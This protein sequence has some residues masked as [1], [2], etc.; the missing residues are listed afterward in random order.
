MSKAKSD[1]PWLDRSGFIPP[2]LA[3]HLI[4]E[5][6]FIYGRGM[7]YYFDGKIYRDTAA[8]FV[9]AK[10]KELLADEYRDS[11][12]NEVVQQ[13]IT[14]AIFNSPTL[15]QDN[16]FIIVRNGALDWR[17]GKLFPHDPAIL[18][19]IFI[20]LEFDP[21]A[22]CPAIEKFFHEVLPAD[23]LDMIFEIIGYL[24]VS[25]NRFERVFLFLGEGANGK[26]TLLRLLRG[27]LGDENIA[28]ESL[29]DLSENRFRLAKLAGKLANFFPDLESR[30]LRDTGLLKAL[31]SGDVISAEFKGRDPFDFANK[32]RMIFSCNSIP[33]A[34]DSSYAFY[35]R[36]CIIRF[37]RTFTTKDADPG[38]IEKLTTPGELSGL[39][40]RA[41][42]ALRVLL[43]LKKF[44]IPESSESE[45][46]KYKGD[47]EHVRRF[48]ESECSINPDFE[49]NK[50]SLYTAYIHWAAAN[51]IRPFPKITFGRQLREFNSSIVDDR[52]GS[53]DR[54]RVWRGINL[55]LSAQAKI[56]GDSEGDE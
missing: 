5:Y 33:R 10:C 47:N 3:A 16:Q 52:A 31:I 43:E 1:S 56:Y 42:E 19:S 18:S 34:N 32:C 13:I 9:K 44:S 39:L 15:D 28:A 21:E 23:S 8:A 6:S 45:L 4:E 20:P 2:K 37:P 51:T 30:A 26:S 38:L 46:K 50:N 24:L 17:E 25:D 49:I 53:M 40:N 22:K 36:L 48:I 41:L 14:E 55:T 35:R 12:G 7:L 27:F 11:R 54:V 29:H